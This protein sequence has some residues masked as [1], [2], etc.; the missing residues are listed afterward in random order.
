MEQL[1]IFS[2]KVIYIYIYIYMIYKTYKNL[3]KYYMFLY[4]LSFVICSYIL[5]AAHIALYSS[6]KG[7]AGTRPGPSHRPGCSPG[8]K[9]NPPRSRSRGHAPCSLASVHAG[10]M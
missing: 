7:L 4:F 1:F 5:S 9:M 10:A 3:L 8:H 6:L 2:Q